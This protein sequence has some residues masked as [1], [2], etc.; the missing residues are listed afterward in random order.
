MPEGEK[1]NATEKFQIITKLYGVLVN[2]DKRQLFDKEGV[3]LDACDDILPMPTFQINNNHIE[4]C[5][6]KF[7]GM[8]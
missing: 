7:I 8:K 2:E 6:H 3:I 4:E 1:E 5:K